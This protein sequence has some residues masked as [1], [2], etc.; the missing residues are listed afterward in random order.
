MGPY[1]TTEWI[2]I[3]FEA[4]KERYDKMTVTYLDY[5]F[6]QAMF[7]LVNFCLIKIHYIKLRASLS[8]NPKQGCG[9]ETCLKTLLLG[10]VGHTEIL[11]TMFSVNKIRD[12]Q[13]N[14]HSTKVCHIRC[15]DSNKRKITTPIPFNNLS[16]ALIHRSS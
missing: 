10:E 11:K 2:S 7:S 16:S 12:P 9:N 1:F 14:F 8:A 6:T 13:P 3:S 4:W 5:F 15:P